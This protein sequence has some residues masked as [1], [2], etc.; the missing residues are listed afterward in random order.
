MVIIIMVS[1]TTNNKSMIYGERNIGESSLLDFARTFQLVIVNSC[2][3]KRKN[4]LVIFCSMVTKIQIDYLLHQK[5]DRDFLQG[6]Q[7]YSEKILLG[8]RPYMID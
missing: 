3:L 6:L 7:D 4:H 1:V 5:G 2:F 8:T